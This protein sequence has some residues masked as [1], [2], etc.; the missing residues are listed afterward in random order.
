M[1]EK[2]VAA[3]CQPFVGAAPA[4]KPFEI[5]NVFGFVD[6]GLDRSAEGDA[7]AA[8]VVAARGFDA[9]VELIVWPV[10]DFG[11][12][13]KHGLAFVQIK[14]QGAAAA[15][16]LVAFVFDAAGKGEPPLRG[17]ADVSFGKHGGNAV[18]V[19]KAVVAADGADVH[20]FVLRAAEEIQPGQAFQA[21]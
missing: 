3:E 6:I 9:G 16:A 7:G 8:G 12:G 5:G 11:F 17:K 15:V 19:V 14:V 4:G 18:F 20:P 21:A 1:V 10:G 2:D 13:Q